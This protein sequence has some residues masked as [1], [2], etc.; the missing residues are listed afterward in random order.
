MARISKGTVWSAEQ[1]ESLLIDIPWHTCYEVLTTWNQLGV[2]C[3]FHQLDWTVHCDPASCKR[4]RIVPGPGCKSVVD[5]A[6]L[7]DV[8]FPSKCANNCIPFVYT[9]V[10]HEMLGA[11]LVD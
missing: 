8:I 4:L 5:T 11:C 6:T 9:R 3:A 10:Q 1:G 2:L 7:T